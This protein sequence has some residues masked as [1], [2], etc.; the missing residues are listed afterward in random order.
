V[1]ILLVIQVA[2]L[3]N[4]LQNEIKP[5]LESINETVNT[6]R[7]TTSFLSDNLVEPVMKMGEYSAALSQVAAILGFGRKTTRK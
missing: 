5:V 2:R 7:G 4:L 3:T 1:L 6:L